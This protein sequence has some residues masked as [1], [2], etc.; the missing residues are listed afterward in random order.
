MNILLAALLFIQQPVQENND[1]EPLPFKIHV[2][3]DFGYPKVY[4]VDEIVSYSR[5]ITDN[6][7]ALV[8]R[9]LLDSS[10][11]NS[12]PGD[13]LENYG[14]AAATLLFIEG[15]TLGV[16]HE[17]G[18]FRSFSL[19]GVRDPVFLN[20]KTGKTIDGSPGNA[21]RVMTQNWLS[22]EIKYSADSSAPAL[23]KFGKSPEAFYYPHFNI[24]V[25]AGGLNMD[26]YGLEGLKERV[27]D[28]D[29]NVLDLFSSWLWISGNLFYPDG[30]NSDVSDYL[31]SLDGIG[32][33]TSATM[34]R[35]VPAALHILSGS[36]L[37]LV[38]GA[39]N[40]LETGEKIIEPISLEVGD[41]S[42]F[43]PEFNSYL[44]L[45][46]PTVKVAEHVG[47]ND[48]LL[49]IS[50]EQAI[51]RPEMEEWGLSWKSG[52]L[53]MFSFSAAAFTNENEKGS[54]FEGGV[55]V[56]PTPWL[57]LGLKRYAGS[58]HT[59]H[60]EVVGHSPWFLE[61]SERGFKGFLELGINF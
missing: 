8:D 14:L 46:G 16:A 58:G 27:I 39:L 59:F 41:F 11:G 6:L 10:R 44:G 52:K 19:F 37:S 33:H 21:Y 47:W 55:T 23:E 3:Q 48:Q 60:R 32:V 15:P 13:R 29:A 17:Y 9:W 36:H 50:F 34:V 18:H 25:E 57:S 49:A 53:E 61:E 12:T 38:S 54:W 28:G 26:R 1:P 56:S 42:F 22:G 51:E 35:G 4:D 5:A 31:K 7:H 45:F 20:T 24:M 40:Y 2:W 30:E 43:L